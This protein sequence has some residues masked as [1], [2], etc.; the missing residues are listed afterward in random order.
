MNN[1]N[2]N[3]NS[4]FESDKVIIEQQGEVTQ[5]GEEIIKEQLSEVTA[6]EDQVIRTNPWRDPISNITWG[7][8]FTA[9][10]FNFL[11]LQ[12][13]LP[14]LGAG[15]LYIGFRDLR[16]EN[17]W[18]N[19]SWILA[20][21]N[22]VIHTGYLIYI[23]TP[24][25]VSLQ[26]NVIIGFIVTAFQISFFLIFR[27]GLKLV[28]QKADTKPPR[29][30]LYSAAIWRIIML[31][32]A[33][34][35]FGSIWLV[36]IP[37][38]ISYFYIFRSMY[39][40]GDDLGDIGYSP[41][42]VHVKV[43]SRPWV[44]RYL[45]V[46]TLLVGICCVGSNHLILDSS[47]FIPQTNSETRK[48]LTRMGFP[49]DILKEVSDE[50]VALLQDAIY[51]EAFSELL[52]FDPKEVTNTNEYNVTT[53]TQEP[54][55]N[56]LKA[57]TIY[58]QLQ[59]NT[60]Y[61]LEYF[62]WQDGNVFSHD[63]FTIGGSVPFEL[64]N[65]MLLYEKNGTSYSSPIPRLRNEVVTTVDWFGGS[66]QSRQITGAVNYPF[67]SETQ[68]G[69]V[70][71]RVKLTESNSILSNGFNYAHYSNPFRTPY[72]ETEQRVLGNQLILNGE[73]MQHYTNFRTKAYLGAI[74]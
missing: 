45:L 8:V 3:D 56:N 24:L 65:G 6:N 44:W 7:F 2:N 39:R 25:S 64:I 71:Y 67:G 32:C 22:V 12:Y 16:K 43:G 41:V 1:N 29:D 35:P 37:M 11:G 27:E 69:Y 30:P 34:T 66:N 55:N 72:A 54:G 70:F 47:E 5:S 50:D 57:T 13:I 26:S 52:M 17:S 14:T 42:E 49:E 51:V 46:C 53:F 10:T 21:I 15:L 20:I 18:L 36:F 28:F 40:L 61:A 19:A 62:Q 48:L 31:I 59:D 73:K 4:D 23:N 60:L 33:M 74:N 38:M 68:R 9:I 63:G 58:I